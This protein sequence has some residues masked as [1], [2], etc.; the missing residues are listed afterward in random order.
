[1]AP[2]L[3][4]NTPAMVLEAL[5][6]VPLDIWWIDENYLVAKA[7]KTALANANNI[8]VVLVGV[9]AY[10]LDSSFSAEILAHF[11]SGKDKQKKYIR[12]RTLADGT[13]ECNEEQLLLQETEQG[14]FVVR[15]GKDILQGEGK[16]YNEKGLSAKAENTRNIHN[17]FIANMNHDIRTPMN[18]II[19]YAEM[20]AGSDLPHREKRFAD[21]IFR[22]GMTLVTILNDL[23]DLS[24]IES[25]RL[26]LKKV[27][28][29]MQELLG[30][31]VDLFRDQA[32]LKKLN[33]TYFVDKDI[34]P[35]VFIDGMRLKQVM[36]NLLSNAVKFTSKG[37]ICITIEGEWDCS[38]S[39][40]YN[41]H[42]V[43][44]D[45]GIG[46][47]VKDYDILSQILNPVGEEV[48]TSYNGRGF[49][50]ALC[51]RLVAMMGGDIV[52]E[53][54]SGVGTTFTVTLTDVSMA[55]TESYSASLA[56]VVPEQLPAAVSRLLIVDDEELIKDVFVDYFSG[57]SMEVLTASTGD[58][59]FEIAVQ[60]K[61]A[62]VFMDLHLTGSKDGRAVTRELRTNPDTEH[63]PVIVMTGELLE[64][65]DIEPLFDGY[66][67]KPFRFE[68]VENI[69][70]KYSLGAG[71]GDGGLN[72]AAALAD[73]ESKDQLFFLSSLWSDE[74]EVQLEKAIFTGGL[75]NAI[76]LGELIKQEGE[77]RGLEA[78]IDFGAEL[79]LC[80][81]EHDIIGV[82]NLLTRLDKND[83]HN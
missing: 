81:T 42:I 54:T 21:T 43:V 74:L 16:A 55:N 53:S 8:D 3:D 27:P 60:H 18:A 26:K 37:S 79:I 66:L 4:D 52:L 35:V 22:S 44:V 76:K 64:D 67:Q 47:P 36:Q 45:T 7:N 62:I 61:P 70:S 71:S 2:K 68:G 56:P 46:I 69:I 31:V 48:V 28:V 29:R 30:E 75:S 51:G 10:E 14:R 13:V 9:P 59:A 20:L 23:M 19:G 63:L 6:N 83:Q 65:T 73:E 57:S 17:E 34:P 50:L 15:Y 25:G 12:T 78:V 38:Q 49:G 40:I 33:V 58:E 80:A 82:E 24:K 1:M 11:F 41:L 5:D 39:N 32:Q 77:T 72:T